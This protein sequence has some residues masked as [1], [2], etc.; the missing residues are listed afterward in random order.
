LDTL[1]Q[2]SD[3]KLKAMVWLLVIIR[4]S[5]L[6]NTV[7]DLPLCQTIQALQLS[8]WDEMLFILKGF[9][10]VDMLHGQETKKLL[11]NTAIWTERAMKF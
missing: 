7:I 10:W 8:S 2:L 3:E 11:S 6:D 4:I 5:V 9:L 1:E